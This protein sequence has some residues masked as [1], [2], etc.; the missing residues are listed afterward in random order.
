MEKELYPCKIDQSMQPAMVYR[1]DSKERRPL[2]VC[3]HT[4][5]YDCTA[6]CSDYLQLAQKYGWNMIFPDFRGPNWTPPACGSDA[7][8]SDLED[9]V[10]YMKETSLVDAKRVYLIG[11]SGGGHC[12]LLMAGRRPDLWAGVSS[13]CPISDVAQW[14]RECKGNGKN[15]KYSQDIE[16]ACGGVPDESP[17]AMREAR[18]RSPL[19]WLPNAENVTLDI[20]TGIHDGHGPFSVPVS[21]AIRAYNILAHPEDRI[22]EEDMRTIVQDETIPEHLRFQGEDPAYGAHTVLLR[23]QSN[24]VRLTLFEGAHTILPATGFHWLARQCQGQE[25]D[26]SIVKPQEDVTATELSR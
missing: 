19:T 25:P 22:S 10:R 8:V 6:N 4:W 13:W 9:A 24:H 21:Q 18:L 5:S 11:G 20:G 12:S 17:D 23:C 2:A 3:L 14:H 1:P 15:D 16:K 26:W 7:V